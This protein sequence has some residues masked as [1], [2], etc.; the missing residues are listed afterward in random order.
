V[1]GCNNRLKRGG[2]VLVRYNFG[3]NILQREVPSISF[4]MTN[5][6]GGFCYLNNESTSKYNGV[7]FKVQDKTYKAIESI[8]SPEPIEGLTNHL[9]RIERQRKNF[10]EYYFMPGNHNSL[11]YET[12]RIQ[13]IRIVLDIR[14]AYMMQQWGRLYT[15]EQQK[16][17]IIIRYTKRTDLRENETSGELEYEA[18]LVIRG[19]LSG[20]RQIK[21]WKKHDYTDDR[22]RHDAPYERHVFDAIELVTDRIILSF[23]TD[24]EQAM[25]ES[26]KVHGELKRLKIEGQKQ[27]QTK[28]LARACAEHSLKQLSVTRPIEGIYAGLPWFFQLWTRDELI[29]AKAMEKL[30]PGQAKQIIMR[31]ASNIGYDGKYTSM[32][33]SSELPAADAAGWLFHRAKSIIQ[34]IGKQERIKLAEQL[35]HIMYLIIKFQTKDGFHYNNAKETWMDTSFEG[36]D[37]QGFC[38]ELQAMLLQMYRTMSELTGN[39]RYQEAEELLRQKTREKFWDGTT[40]KDRLD[41]DTIRPN[42]FIAAYFYP[43]L[44]TKEEWTRCFKNALQRLW[45][46]WG[47]ISTIDT[48]HRLFQ[49]HYTGADNRSYHR[50]DSWYYLNN[51]AALVMQRTEPAVFAEYIKRILNASTEEILWRGASGH[52]AEVSSAR[53]Q[54]SEGCI[55]QAWSCAMYLELLEELENQPG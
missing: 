55:C 21:E 48:G 38:I 1:R 27:T 33:P 54:G 47:G 8:E 6:T 44:L 23:D 32:F 30:D 24:L 34:K 18:F 39:P 3:G 25:R 11:V 35:Q 14:E 31:Y 7:F 43:E 16:D 22:Q 50:G 52:H 46:G 29:C 40:L 51:L 13:I 10:S 12:S 20:A 26:R 2:L 41:D 5:R 28:D 42:V 36:D 53:M 45:L 19:N 37:R 49:D 4:V 9:W 17:C 15:I